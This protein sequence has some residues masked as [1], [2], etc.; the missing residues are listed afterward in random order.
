MKNRSSLLS[1]E[2]H[3]LRNLV[4]LA[5][6]CA[7]S[8]LASAQVAW[9]LGWS[10]EFNG[11][12]INT[13]NWTFDYGSLRVNNEVEYYCGPAGDP[14]N[15]PPCDSANPN[16]YADGNGHLII[17]AFQISSNA[18][19]YSNSWTSARLKSQSLQTPQYG[20]V[21]SSMKLPIGAGIWPAF[22]ALGTNIDT[23][24]WPNCGEQDYMENV[25]ASAG[26]GPGVISSTLHGPTYSGANGLSK[27]YHFPAGEEVDT[28]YHTYGAI[29]SPSMVQFY[30]DDPA[31]IFFVRTASDVPGGAN[32]WAFNRPFFLLLNL[33]IG[34]TGSWPG[35][36]DSTTPNPAIMSVDYVRQ[37]TASPLPAPSLGTPAPISVK[38]GATSGNTTTVQLASTSNIGRVYLSCTTNAPKAT[39]AITSSDALNIYTVDFSRSLTATATVAITT[40]ANAALAHFL[41]GGPAGIASGVIVMLLIVSACTKRVRVRL[42]ATLSA[43]F[44]AILLVPSCGGGSSSGSGGGGGGGGG[45]TTPGN[46]SITVSA[47]TVSN[48]GGAADATVNI[49]L[50][51]Q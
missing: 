1:F 34:G 51:V 18:S 33:A 46:Y 21:E 24:G 37:Y 28:A 45:G 47:Y 31:N 36:P 14:K 17:Q 20:R 43:T 39:C 49:P 6:A 30:V 48:T 23:I 8:P 22:W 19:P 25:P 16:A 15:Q 50:T 42:G 13:A 27:Q 40:T 32:Q 35:P 29:W 7:I 41:S 11:T 26:Q 10:D 4:L 38:A 2:A 3:A 5:A 44:L 9:N 12:S